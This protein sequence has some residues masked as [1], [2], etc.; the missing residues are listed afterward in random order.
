MDKGGIGK[1]TSAINLGGA[2]ADAGEDVLLFGVDPQGFT[3]ST[4][5]FYIYYFSDRLTL[6]NV[7]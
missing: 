1:S 5:G 7:L 6:I 3:T 4:L 2:L